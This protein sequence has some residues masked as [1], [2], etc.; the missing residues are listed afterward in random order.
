[1]TRYP[2]RVTT[3]AALADTPLAR[4]IDELEDHCFGCG[5]GNPQGLQLRFELG[6]TAAGLPTAAATVQL[7]RLHQGAPGFV[8]GGILAT[9]MDEVMSKLNRPLGVLA[10]TRHMDVSYLRPAPLLTPLALSAVHLRREGRKL[11]HH[12]HLHDPGGRLL[13]ECKGLFI[14]VDPQA[15]GKQSGR[16]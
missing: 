14:A 1:M 5:L 12:A 6:T 16:L 8:H 9:L 3:P 10:M 4:T 15:L 13:V 11:F 2:D 7:T